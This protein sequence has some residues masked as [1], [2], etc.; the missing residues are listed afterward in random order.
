MELRVNPNKRSEQ[1]IFRLPK[2]SS[3]HDHLFAPP[4]CQTNTLLGN[5]SQDI[6]ES[7]LSVLGFA[8]FLEAAP[9]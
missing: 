5:I 6:D 7:C 1:L 3:K 4:F 9:W 2:A 8:A